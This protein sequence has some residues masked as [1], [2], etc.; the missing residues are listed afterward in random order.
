[1]DL[2][3]NPQKLQGTIPAIASKSSAHRLLIC[4][5]L[6]DRKT[7]L[8]CAT[9]SQDIFATTRCLQG[10]GANISHRQGTFSVEP[11]ME[12]HTSLLPCGESGSTLRFL[13]PVVAALGCGGTFLMEGRLPERPLFPLDR[14]LERHGITLSKP[15]KDKL[16]VSGRLLPGAYTLP[17]N[18]SSQYISGLLFALPFL[19][20][21][22]TLTI[23]GNLESKPYVDMTMDALQHFGVNIS[24]EKGT[25]L[26][27]PSRYRSSGNLEVEGDWSNAA[28]WLAA[29]HMGSSVTVTGLKK[30]SL[31]GD[32]SILNCLS[33]LGNDT[34]IDVSNIP[35]LVPILA[36]A[37]VCASGKTHFVNA[38]RL[39][40]KES[41]RIETVKAMLKALGGIVQDTPDSLTVTGSPL[42][43]GTVHACKDHR[44]A[45]AAAIAATVASSPVTIVGAEAVAKSYPAFWQDYAKLGGQFKEV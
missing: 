44:I 37:A 30:D 12:G 31:Q 33:Q 4:A 39:R 23:E 22:S 43:G 20:R 16:T 18:V 29:S 38:A 5:A 32:R 40:L 17:G 10:L 45:M 25:F 36:V 2:C 1:M 24:R 14:E 34:A 41:D 19:E 28:F 11:I 3:I 9:T 13:L 35:D 7:V 6:S 27:S 21:E 8:D 15:E 26:I 42:S